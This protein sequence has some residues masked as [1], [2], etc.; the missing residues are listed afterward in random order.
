MG[1]LKK[2]H[3]WGAARRTKAAGAAPHSVA[4]RRGKGK[5]RRGKGKAR[6]GKRKARRGKRK[7]HRAKE[8]A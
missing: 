7:A 3:K 8:N 4:A 1:I 2:F 6:R 5:A